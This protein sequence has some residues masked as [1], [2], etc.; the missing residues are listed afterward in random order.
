MVWV[1][2]ERD[3]WVD[4]DSLTL[5]AEPS[6]ESEVLA[7]LVNDI[8]RGRNCFGDNGIKDALI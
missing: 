2:I 4:A 7:T 1:A 5:R 3:V 8:V 6:T